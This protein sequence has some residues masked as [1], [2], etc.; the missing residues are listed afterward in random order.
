M[1]LSP[2]IYGHPCLGPPKLLPP[3]QLSIRRYIQSQMTPRAE[4]NMLEDGEGVA[5][6]EIVTSNHFSYA[7]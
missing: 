2:S 3:L 1:S 7:L 6:N 4:L 5:F